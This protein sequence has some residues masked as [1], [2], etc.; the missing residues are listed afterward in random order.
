MLGGLTF[1]RCYTN[2]ASIVNRLFPFKELI[3]DRCN[4]IRR[5]GEIDHR[6]HIDVKVWA[7]AKASISNKKV[8][9]PLF[10]SRVHKRGQTNVVVVAWN[11][12]RW[13]K[14]NL[15]QIHLRFFLES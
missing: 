3:N 13:W 4:S 14:S 10:G 5:Q 9:V 1:D 8:T 2:V 11:R 6:N 15:K 12:G 7:N